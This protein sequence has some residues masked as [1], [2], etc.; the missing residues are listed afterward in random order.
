MSSR[1]ILERKGAV[2]CIGNATVA[3][4]KMAEVGVS[5]IVSSLRSSVGETV[6]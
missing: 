3:V 4:G 5:E 1:K 2:V 6:A